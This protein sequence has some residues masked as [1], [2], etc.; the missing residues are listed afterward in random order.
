MSESEQICEVIKSNRGKSKLH[1]DGYTYDRNRTV[2][3]ISY[4][5]CEKRKRSQCKGTAKTNYEDNNHV[6]LKEGGEHNHPK[7]HLRKQI[8]DFKAKLKE[9][10]AEGMDTNDLINEIQ[11]GVQFDVLEHLPSEEALRQIIYREKTRQK[12]PAFE[13]IFVKK[14]TTSTMVARNVSKAQM[15]QLLELMAED[16]V[17]VD[18]KVAFSDSTKME[19]W[20]RVAFHLNSVESG[21][22]KNAWQWCKVFAD[23]KK[24]TEKKANIVLKRI[25]HP[26]PGRKS[27]NPIHLEMDSMEMRLL[28]LVGYPL[29]DKNDLTKLEM[30]QVTKKEAPDVSEFNLN[31]CNEYLLD[32]DSF[33]LQSDHDASDKDDDHN[34]DENDTTFLEATHIDD[35][36][37]KANRYLFIISW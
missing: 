13:E 37:S 26:H 18:G 36:N 27:S 33:M 12:E 2:G 8:A 35:T 5:I 1:I 32:N 29:D 17:L 14:P 24:A 20:K 3:T 9:K 11:N 23:W 34:F 22:H 21:G 10:V 19:F 28:K 4:W 6:L 31:Q 7:D 30:M 25:P 16:G 15:E